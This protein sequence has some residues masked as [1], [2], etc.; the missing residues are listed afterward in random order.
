MNSSEHKGVYW[1]KRSGKWEVRIRSGR[2]VHYLGL[3]DNESDA[4]KA[5][6]DKIGMIEKQKYDKNRYNKMKRTKKYSCMSCTEKDGKW[7]LRIKVDK[8]F[9]YV[10]RFDSFDR[11]IAA[12]DSNYKKDSKKELMKL[13][14]SVPVNG[15]EPRKYDCKFYFLCLEEHLA[16]DEFPA[17]V[18]EEC[19]RYTK[20]D[21]YSEQYPMPTAKVIV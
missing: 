3:F 21:N 1:N 8:D 19:N 16:C 4:I 13:I 18:C 10:G 12:Y 20:V 9:K 14:F 2:R 5:Y 15:V 11:V 7:L 17:S 6:E